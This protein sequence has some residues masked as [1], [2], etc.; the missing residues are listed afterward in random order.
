MSVRVAPMLAFPL[1]VTVPLTVSTVPMLFAVS[2]IQSNAASAAGADSQSNPRAIPDNP[3]DAFF[4]FIAFSPRRI[5][6]GGIKHEICQ[7]I[8][9]HYINMIERVRELQCKEIRHLF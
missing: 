8:I 6:A 4:D 5:A 1:T 2:S 3:K 7:D 9:I